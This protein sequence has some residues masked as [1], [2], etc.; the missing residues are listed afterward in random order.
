MGWLKSAIANEREDEDFD[1]LNAVKERSSADGWGPLI[2]EALSILESPDQKADWQAATAVLFWASSERPDWGV[3]PM[4][5]VARLYLC[6]ELGDDEL[7][8]LFAMADV[9]VMISRQ[10]PSTGA[11]EGFG[12]CY[13]EAAACGRPSISG[14]IGGP[15][16]AV[17]DGVTG[18]HVDVLDSDM[19]A[20][21]VISL[22]TDQDLA[23]QMGR[24]GR[25]MVLDR[26][27]KTNMLHGISAVVHEAAAA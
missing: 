17:E 10:E 4:A 13:L 11:L 23:K 15:V 7:P 22:L 24:A 21:H 27:T 16:D 8:A 25:Q 14:N 3:D 9:H 2:A 1:L 12:I 20:K 19:V 26:F 6:V 5:I 18:Y